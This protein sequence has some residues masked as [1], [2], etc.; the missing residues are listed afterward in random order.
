MQGSAVPHPS[1]FNGCACSSFRPHALLCSR[2]AE[3]TCRQNATFCVGV[4]GRYGG[5]VALGSMQE[6]L[7]TLQPRLA[8]DEDKSVRDNAVGALSRLVD[9]FTTRLPLG[10]I[11]PGIVSSLPLTGEHA[12]HSGPVP[13]RLMQTCPIPSHAD[14]CHPRLMQ[15]SHPGPASSHPTQ[16]RV[17]QVTLARTSLPC[18][19]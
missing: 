10:D 4:L 11:L 9:A 16:F 13:S 14:L 17:V 3:V 7:S 5:E 8:P 1:R 18:A 12:H 19:V 2:D 6:I 15:S